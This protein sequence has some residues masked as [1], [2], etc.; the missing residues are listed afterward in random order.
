M[1]HNRRENNKLA[2]KMSDDHCHFNASTADDSGP[3]RPTSAAA[4]RRPPADRATS[5]APST[6]MARSTI[7]SREYAV[8]MDL[9]ATCARDCRTSALLTYGRVHCARAD[10]MGFLVVNYAN[11]WYNRPGI[12]FTFVLRMRTPIPIKFRSRI[13]TFL[14]RL[15]P[16]W[17]YTVT[18]SSIRSVVFQALQANQLPSCSRETRRK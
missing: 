13:S 2:G 12:F 16:P 7:E 11:L 4:R 8:R 5:A 10:A 9:L 17:T 3:A 14:H 18:Q 6:T 15:Q 1:A